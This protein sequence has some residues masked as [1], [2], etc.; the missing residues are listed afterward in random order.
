ME[1]ARG[2]GTGS[3]QPVP[4]QA[5]EETRLEVWGNKAERKEGKDR[6]ANRRAVG[7]VHL[8]VSRVR[9][10]GAPNPK[11]HSTSFLRSFWE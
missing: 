8:P 5:C 6:D 3:E 2:L 11:R 9:G 4:E 10:G 1:K 7:L